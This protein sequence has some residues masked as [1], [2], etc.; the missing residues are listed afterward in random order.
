MKS[1]NQQG[2]TL[3]EILLTVGVIGV[4]ASIAILAINPAKQLWE[5]RNTQRKSHAGTLH[6]ALYQYAIA[7]GAFPTGITTTAQDICRD[8]QSGSCVSLSDLTDSQRYLT[9]LPLAPQWEESTTIGYQVQL[10]SGGRWVSVI[11][12][13][14]ENGATI[15]APSV[16][17]LSGSG[18]GGG[19]GAVF[20]VTI[21]DGAYS[22]YEGEYE[23]TWSLDPYD[24]TIYT[25]GTRYWSHCDATSDFTANI[26]DAEACSP[27]TAYGDFGDNLVVASQT[28][29]AESDSSEIGDS[30]TGSCP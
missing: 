27:N 17:V 16:G 5:A 6:K 4:L 28:I 2:F 15:I 7:N 14:P 13:N 30:A 26:D 25:N 20:C 18:G 1:A 21:T 11:S 24:N 9:A 10:G 8:G 23:E 19:G 22:S 29:Y 12:S 3:L